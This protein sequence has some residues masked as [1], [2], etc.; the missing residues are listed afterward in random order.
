MDRATLGHVGG[1]ARG[2]IDTLGG[3]VGTYVGIAN[4]CGLRERALAWAALAGLLA[5]FVLVPQPYTSLVWLPYSAAMTLG[6]RAVSRRQE[7]C[8]RADAEE[9]RP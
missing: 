8:R 1:I 2:V 7:A 4:T 9:P 5:W 3:A 6:L